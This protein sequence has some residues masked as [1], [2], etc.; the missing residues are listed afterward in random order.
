MDAGFAPLV[1][2]DGPT[3]LISA[4]FAFTAKELASGCAVEMSKHN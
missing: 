1:L 4:L 2:E 3:Q